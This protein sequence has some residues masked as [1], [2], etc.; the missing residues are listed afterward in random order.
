YRPDATL[1]GQTSTTTFGQNGSHYDWWRS[2]SNWQINGSDISDLEGRWTVKL[3]VDGS[4]KRTISFTIRYEFKE[5][6]LCKDHQASSPYDPIN[7]TSIFA[8]TD[9]KAETWCKLDKVSN[10]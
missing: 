1:Y 6:R 9:A 3:Y 10:P 7:P 2:W 4:Y 8:Q 5:H